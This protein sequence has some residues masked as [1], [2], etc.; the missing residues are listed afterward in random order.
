MKSQLLSCYDNIVATT[1]GWETQLS[2]VDY[3]ITDTI[4]SCFFLAWPYTEVEQSQ[5]CR[6]VK[7][8]RLKYFR[9]LI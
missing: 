4:F 3:Y 2:Q 1:R 6:F 9:S 5:I 7:M 8:C